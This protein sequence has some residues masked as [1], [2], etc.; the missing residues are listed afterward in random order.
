MA[1]QRVLSLYLAANAAK[2]A[3]PSLA[4]QCAVN[5]CQVPM[6]VTEAPARN[7]RL[8]SSQ[9]Q[10]N[11]HLAVNAAKVAVQSLVAQYAANACQ[12]HIFTPTAHVDHAL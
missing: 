9:T 11:W 3:L 5:A 6:S 4:V 8:V 7:V 10:L 12:V 1:Q 2:V